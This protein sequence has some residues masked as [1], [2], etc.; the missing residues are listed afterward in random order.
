MAKRKAVEPSPFHHIRRA[1]HD[2]VD[3]CDK[4]AR[5]CERLAK[6][7]LGWV[8]KD[9]LHE[10]VDKQTLHGAVWQDAVIGFADFSTPSRG[11]NKGWNVIHALAVHPDER[12]KG[13]GRT[14]LYSVPTPI[15]LKCPE[16]INGAE[17]N[18]A[19]DFYK[20]A[21]MI[22]RDADVTQSTGKRLNV[23]EMKV[24]LE[25][26]RGGN[27]SIPEVANRSGWAYGTRN[28]Y[29]VFGYP[30]HIDIE[31]KKYHDSN[32]AGKVKIWAKYIEMIAKY[33]PVAALVADYMTPEQKPVMLQQIQDLKDL[34]VIRVMCCPKFE[35][36][37]YDISDDVIIAVSIPSKYAAYIPADDELVG[38]RLH[39][40]GGSPPKW[41]GSR[42]A[43]NPTGY[44][45]RF[46]GIGAQVISADANLHV[47]KG[48]LGDVWSNGKWQNT[49][50]RNQSSA[51]AVA[52]GIAIRNQLHAIADT[53]Q[54]QLNRGQQ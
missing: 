20:R 21:G 2:D 53:S 50:M 43:G 37:C 25:L 28:D 31:F 27:K 54:S 47:R 32:D 33:R 40:L 44:I 9:G 17:Y 3:A 1:T 26:V 36:A 49:S 7:S 29:S 10:S 22:L 52:S 24:L 51:L 48:Y 13:V 14:L 42:S 18:V 16:H 30:L 19:N 11:A 41:F 46:E 8:R 35:G 4:I 12:I 15:R 39:L 23:W 5:A 6:G 38:R 45:A 34:G